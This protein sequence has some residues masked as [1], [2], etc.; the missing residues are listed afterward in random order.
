MSLAGD[1]PLARM[2]SAWFSAMGITTAAGLGLVAF[3]L[4][5]GLPNIQELPFPNA[6]VEFDDARRELN[7]PT[8]SLSP[9]RPA[10]DSVPS[11][12]RAAPTQAGARTPDARL[13]ESQVIATTPA[14]QTAPVVQPPP[15]SPKPHGPAPQPQPRSPSPV[16]SPA[17]PSPPPTSQPAASAGVPKGK[18]A[19]LSWAPGQAKVKG[20]PAPTIPPTPQAAAEHAKKHAGK[21]DRGH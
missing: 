1:G 8:V 9:A 3:A 12:A 16:A 18:G 4:N 11:P 20:V 13:V 21:S 5:H 7:A 14:P 6:P 2:R 15:P 19:G 10:R 17:A